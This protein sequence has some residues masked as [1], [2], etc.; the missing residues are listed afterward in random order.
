MRMRGCL[1]PYCL[2]RSRSNR[3]R[4]GED[5][6]VEAPRRRE[7]RAG[8]DLEQDI[9]NRLGMKKKSLRRP[10]F[11]P[12]GASGPHDPASLPPPSG[13]EVVWW[14]WGEYLPQPRYHTTPP[15]RRE[16]HNPRADREIP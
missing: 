11:R 15:P 14:W 4:N 2:G 12:V 7:D 16:R 1:R 9:A 6:G 10:Q 13:G 8:N 3:L 5:M